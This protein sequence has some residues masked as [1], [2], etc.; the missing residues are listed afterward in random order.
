MFFISLLFI[1]LFWN[2]AFANASDIKYEWARNTEAVCMEITV[3]TE[4]SVLNVIFIWD[5]NQENIF[6]KLMIK[7]VTLSVEPFE[8]ASLARLFAATAS[9]F[10]P[11]NEMR[12]FRTWATA[13][14]LLKMS[15]RP[16]EARTANSGRKW[17]SALSLKL[18]TSG[19]ETTTLRSFNG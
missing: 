14:S 13:S 11:P 16:S 3:M 12:C 17:G 1:L 18:R 6:L 8:K 5:E 9:D 2:L 10:E 7:T 19:S 15:Q 4:L